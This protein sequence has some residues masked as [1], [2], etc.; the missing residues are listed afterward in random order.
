M[1]F[2]VD[3]L[4]VGKYYQCADVPGPPFLVLE[5]KKNNVGTFIKN[6]I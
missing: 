2:F 1:S 6:T 5:I 4:V 3:E